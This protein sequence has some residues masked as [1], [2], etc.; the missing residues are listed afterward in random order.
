MKQVSGMIN[1]DY[2]VHGKLDLTG[3]VSGTVRVA[4]DGSFH[5]HGTVTKDLILETGSRAALDGTVTGNVINRG[6]R[7][8]LRGSV[9]GSVRHESGETL[10]SP[11]AL[12][13]GGISGAV[14][15]LGDSD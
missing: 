6:G 4:S 8:E 14:G 7:L 15:V 12:V 9:G 13:E 5:L 1:G 2:T 10:I 3:M 11:K